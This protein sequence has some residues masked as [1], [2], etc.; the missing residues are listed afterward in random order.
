[1]IYLN[2]IIYI[3][4]TIYIIYI[5]CIHI[6]IYIMWEEDDTKQLYLVLKVSRH[7]S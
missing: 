3:I 2:Y 7:A 6:Y 5:L 1:M 4:Y